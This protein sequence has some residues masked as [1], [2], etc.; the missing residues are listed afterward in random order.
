MNVGDRVMTPFG[1][2]S[3]VEKVGGFPSVLVEHDNWH[4]GHG[5][6]GVCR[7]KYTGNRCY[8]FNERDLK[9]LEDYCEKYL[10]EYEEIGE[11][12]ASN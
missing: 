5:G 8:Y 6:N 7:G 10:T 1:I 11:D 3:I 9:L 2:G 4:N 12:D